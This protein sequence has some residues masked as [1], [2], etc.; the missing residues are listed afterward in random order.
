MVALD[1]LGALHDAVVV[2]RDLTDDH[3]DRRAR[4]VLHFAE[5]T[6]LIRVVAALGHLPID[7]HDTRDSDA[8]GVR[9]MFALAQTGPC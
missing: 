8:I 7:D 1:M 2:V 9:F 3:G 4:N 5:I 6:T